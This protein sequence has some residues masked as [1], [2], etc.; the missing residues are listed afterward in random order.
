MSKRLS[1]Q[2]NNKSSS[3]LVR[4]QYGFFRL[5]FISSSR[6]KK[7][8]N[9]CTKGGYSGQGI[10]SIL[11]FLLVNAFYNFRIHSESTNE[12]PFC[13]EL[14][15]QCIVTNI[16][17]DTNLRLHLISKSVSMVNRQGYHLVRTSVHPS[18]RNI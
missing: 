18:E 13:L 11:C 14:T 1:A 8:E 3:C 15:H 2:I 17:R 10:H 5:F 16:S 6:T 4:G 12:L 9:S 7:F